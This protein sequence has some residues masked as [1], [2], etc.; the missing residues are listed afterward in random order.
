MIVFFNLK[1]LLVML[2]VAFGSTESL[3]DLNVA[4][5]KN[6]V[7]DEEE[8]NNEP[9]EIIEHAVGMEFDSVEEALDF[10][11]YYGYRKGFGVVK[12]SNH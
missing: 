12:R 9:D 8:E 10:Y 1:K 7:E 5:V 4:L 3:L 2:L 6:E 11:K